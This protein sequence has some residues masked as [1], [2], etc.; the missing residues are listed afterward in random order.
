MFVPVKDVDRVWAEIKRA[1]EEGLLGSESKVATAK[2]RPTASSK[3]V[4]VICVYTYDWTDQAD[5][6]RI[7]AAL[8]ELG[9]TRKS[10]YKTDEDTENRKYRVTG[11]TRISKY[12]E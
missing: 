4:R 10:P 12:F 9:I 1:T 3:D 2:D 8:R 7:R 6:R 11:H 5:V